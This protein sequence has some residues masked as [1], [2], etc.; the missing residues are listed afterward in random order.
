MKT[1]TLILILLLTGLSLRAQTPA[2]DPAADDAGINFHFESVDV[3]QVLEVYA[4]LVNRTVLRGALPGAQIILQ[5]HSPL[6]KSEAIQA[7]QAV[8][9][10]NGISVVNI[11]EKF[12]KVVPSEQAGSVGG[13]LESVDAAHIPE[14]GS[15]MTHIVQLQ[16]VKPSVMQPLLVPLAK[17]NN[18]FPIDD[19]GILV[20]RDYAENVKRMLEMI[21][22]VDVSIPAEYVSEVIPI[23]YALAEDIASA[24]NS[25]GGSGGGSTVS[26]GSS[27]ANTSPGAGRPTGI[28][29]GGVNNGVGAGGLNQPRPF[30]AQATVNGTPAT[31]TTVQQ[32]IQNILAQA[33]NPQR[34]QGQQGQQDQ[35]QVFGQAKIIADQRANSLLVFATRSDIDKIKE[36]VS[37]LDVLLSQVL[38]ESIIMDVSLNSGSSFGVSA[39]QRPKNINQNPNINTAGGM[40]NGQPFFNFLNSVSNTFPGN[41]T[42]TLPGNSLSYFGNIGPTWD[43]AVQAAANDG[44]VTVVQRPRIQTSQAKQASFFVGESVPVINS[45]YYNIGSGNQSTYSQLSVGVRLDVTPFINPDG[46]VVMDIN[47]EVNDLISSTGPNGEL[48]PTTSQ[49][50]LNS[51]IAVK[52]RDTIIL[53]GFIRSDKK[54]GKSGVPY[55]QNIPLLGNLFSS[56]TD[57][58]TRSEL[59]VLMRPTVLKTPELAAAQA[60]VEQQRLPGI[61]A[62]AAQDL[63]DERKQIEAQLKLGNIVPEKKTAAQFLPYAPN[64]TLNTNASPAT[65]P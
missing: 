28:N 32:R 41:L 48:A 31:G 37:K 15:Y 51:E 27:G 64:G 19:N 40:N 20:I 10:I 26:I 65:T 56:R 54:H 60:V 50:T 47:Q 11:G 59:I 63:K 3:A 4:G 30:G 35:I 44:S 25:L 2:P 43:V 14:L 58:K 23:K 61:S 53:G 8:L 62:A 7:L 39:S 36:V 45:T 24:L 55:L 34:P 46:L 16:Y 21:A 5:T 13:S 22:K 17:V 6:T 12:V 33:T 38:I 52:D 57:S 42:S 9:A 18:M 29:S 49:R 1:T